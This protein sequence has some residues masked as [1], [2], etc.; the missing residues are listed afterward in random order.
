MVNIVS[1]VPQE[2][3]FCL[4]LFLLD[5]TVLFS[6]LENMLYSYVAESDFTL[7]AIVLS[8]GETAAV[9]ESLNRCL[10]RVSMWCDL[11]K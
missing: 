6:I 1:G 2:S 3:V 10:N 7:V 11:W 8:P 9:T 5:T 4:Q